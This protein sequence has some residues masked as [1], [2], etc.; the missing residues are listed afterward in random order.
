MITS[1]EFNA[2][3]DET[4]KVNLPHLRVVARAQPLDK[5]RL[6][7]LL[8]EMGEVVAVTGD[9]T[10]DA[11]ALKRARR[12]AGHGACR[13]RSRQGSQQDHTS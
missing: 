13:Q 10:N 8:Q 6:V 7:R 5:Y 2:W 1:P 4:L 12:G 3:D 9:G 11:P